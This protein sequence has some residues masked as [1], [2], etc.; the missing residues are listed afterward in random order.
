[1]S[2]QIEFTLSYSGNESEKHQID[3]YDVSQALI[4][5]QRSLALTT[6]FILNNQI[7]TQVPALKG[8]KIVAIP[9]EA[10][11]W[12]IT[13]V[14]SVLGAGI[15]GAVTADRTSVLGNVITSAY[16]Y[17]I[18]ETLGFHVDFDKTLGQQYEEL[19]KNDIKIELQ[20]KLR[21]DSLIE[22][23]ETAVKQ[24]HRPIVE[25]RSATSAI[26]LSSRMGSIEAIGHPFNLETYEYLEYSAMS[27]K[28][29]NYIGK[30]SSYNANT[31]KGR[32]YLAKE[33]RPI[34]FLLSEQARTQ[35][36]VAKITD[37]LSENAKTRFKGAG[38]IEFNAFAFNS[39]TDRLKTLLITEIF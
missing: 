21:F 30:V 14:L 6:H 4:G 15:Y 2:L 24:I 26:I 23:C 1:M 10:G 38:E 25:S 28:P 17:V 22:K 19:H 12:K 31:F 35:Y 13:A 5:F 36:Y 9:P 16:D 39:K 37:S 20:P 18:S 11:S 7:I 33:N 32:I 3:F 34:P 29:D 8:A 27:D